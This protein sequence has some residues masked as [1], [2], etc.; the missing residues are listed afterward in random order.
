MYPNNK[1]SQKP[2]F[3]PLI[4]CQ[5]QQIITNLNK[6]I[7]CLIQ[8]VP[9]NR[10]NSKK[11]CEVIIKHIYKLI[12]GMYVL[13]STFHHLKRFILRCVVELWNL[14]PLVAFAF[15]LKHTHTLHIDF[16]KSVFAIKRTYRYCAS[17]VK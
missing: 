12:F 17:R 4:L 3:I 9:I 2:Q 8:I 14:R 1:I 5:I 13:T 6:Y 7:V 15:R 11:F 10:L 16:Y